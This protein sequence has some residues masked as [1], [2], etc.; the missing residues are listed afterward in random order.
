MMVKRL[1]CFVLVAAIVGGTFTLALDSADSEELRVNNIAVTIPNRY[2]GDVNY[3]NSITNAD[4]IIMSQYVVNY[5]TFSQDQILRGDINN[6]SSVTNVDVILTARYLVGLSFTYLQE[7]SLLDVNGY[8]Y[9]YDS[10]SSYI[11]D[12]ISGTALWNSY[13]PGVIRRDISGTIRDVIIADYYTNSCVN[14]ITEYFTKTVKFNTRLMNST[15]MEATEIIATCAHECGHCLGISHGNK[16][17][18]M[19]PT[20]PWVMQLGYDDQASYDAV[21]DLF[22]RPRPTRDSNEMS[23][24]N[25]ETVG[26]PNGLKTDYYNNL[27]VCYSSASYCINV[28][29]Y[30]E[31]VGH[32]DFVFIGRVVEDLGE[33]YENENIIEVGNEVI[34]L[35]DPYTNY[36]VEVLNNIKGSLDSTISLKKYGGLDQSKKCYIIMED[37]FLPVEGETYIFVA[38]LQ[39]DG[40][41]QVCGKNST[42]PYSQGQLDAIVD[43]ANSQ[44]KGR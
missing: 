19:N 43:A 7:W 44:K 40:T 15:Y 6:D 24:T 30:D 35:N 38:Y 27:P 9:W 28:D 5:V 31:L 32:A 1:F 4:L 10:G 29:D 36:T 23:E 11:N 18:I 26:I 2:P 22:D 33:T 21:W 14:A 41:L 12:W 42:I 34:V 3:D 37:D 17:D 20:T 39:K 8:L 25:E 13:I 16:F